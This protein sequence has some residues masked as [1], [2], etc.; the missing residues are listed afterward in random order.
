MGFYLFNNPQMDISEE[1][2]RNLSAWMEANPA[3]DT[4]KKL[5]KASHVGFGTVQRAKNGSGNIT[6]QNLEL[7]A[8]AFKRSAI[9]L[10]TESG[11]DLS[12]EPLPPPITLVANEPPLDERELL[13]GYRDA[14]P[15]V[16]EIMLEAARRATQKQNFS[17][18]S[19]KQ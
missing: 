1:I 2:S 3:L 8:R 19:D 9:D 4:L 17:K 10:I 7:I 14:S 16:R 12:R 15:D 5:S 13:Q 11:A 18:R 6:V